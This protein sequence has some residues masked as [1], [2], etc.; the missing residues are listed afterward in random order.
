MRE[1]KVID[2]LIDILIYP[3]EGD[4]PTYNFNDINQRSPIVR[5]CQLIYRILKLC[6]KNS[7]QN[8]FYIAQWISHF[9]HQSMMANENNNL[10]ADSTVN[11]LTKN[12]KQ[13]LDK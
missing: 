2:L 1:L 3:F 6:A 12:N 7:I 13:L 8:K 10:M 11:E 5:I 9:F 4:Q